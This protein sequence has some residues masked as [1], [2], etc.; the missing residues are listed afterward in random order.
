MKAT[1][2][3]EF[4]FSKLFLPSAVYLCYSSVVTKRFQ[5]AMSNKGQMAVQALQ[6]QHKGP[7]AF[8]RLTSTET[9]V[10]ELRAAKSPQVSNESAGWRNKL[11]RVSAIGSNGVRY[12]VRL[13]QQGASGS[14]K[15]HRLPHPDP[16]N[17]D[18]LGV[19][20][21]AMGKDGKRLIRSSRTSPSNSHAV[22]VERRF[23]R[24]GKLVDVYHWQQQLGQRWLLTATLFGERVI[25]IEF[26]SK[27]A[28][29]KHAEAHSGDSLAWRRVR[30]RGKRSRRKARGSE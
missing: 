29:L 28:A 23:D 10:R 2:L 17:A 5:K 9:T 25:T 13:M 16:E 15:Y 11:P 12:T 24:R 21:D 8:T 18:P 26:A 1:F 19:R 30:G 27:T 22:Q 14:V 20:G 6:K 3:N 7:S 4:D